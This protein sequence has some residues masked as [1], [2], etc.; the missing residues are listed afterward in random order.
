MEAEI[1]RLT[2]R[3]GRPQHVVYD[4]PTTDFGPLNRGRVAEVA[5]AIRRPNGLYLLQTKRSYPRNTFRLP[6]GGIKRG[7]GIEHALLRETDEETSLE[8]EIVRFAALVDYRA[9]HGH[10]A[11]SSYLFVLDERRGNL[12]PRDPSEGITGWLEADP[13]DLDAAADR[14]RSCSGGWRSW[15]YFRALV[16]DALVQSIAA[17]KAPQRR[18][19]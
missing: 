16:L 13:D 14:L 15:G 19:A 7:E 17:Q 3:Y 8:C 4:L 5:M 11:F 9:P 6:T 10:R 1:A 18:R 2:R 12:K